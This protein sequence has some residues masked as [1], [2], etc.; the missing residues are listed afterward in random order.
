MTW[1]ILRLLLSG[2]TATLSNKHNINDVIMTSRS[3]HRTSA[4]FS[5]KKADSTK[6]DGRLHG[7]WTQSACYHI[8]NENTDQMRGFWDFSWPFSLQSTRD[9]SNSIGL[10]NSICENLMW[11]W[12]FHYFRQNGPTK[13]VRIRTLSDF[14][15]SDLSEFYC[16]W[17][18]LEWDAMVSYLKHLNSARLITGFGEAFHR[19]CGCFAKWEILNESEKG[20]GRRV[21]GRGGQKNAEKP[22]TRPFFDEDFFRN[23]DVRQNWTETTVRTRVQKCSIFVQS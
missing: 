9:S 10:R 15:E 19:K 14:T 18:M 20:S 4:S 1:L 11:A 12:K 17:R 7:I 13:S 6:P 2:T 16:M 23:N 22:D 5:G 21:F 8:R 3:N